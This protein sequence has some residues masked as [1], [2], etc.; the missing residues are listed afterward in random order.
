MLQPRLQPRARLPAQT[1][2]DFNCGCGFHGGDGHHHIGCRRV[3]L[4][5]ADHRC[6][7][8]CGG[9][10]MSRAQKVFESIMRTKGHSEFTMNDTG[11]YLNGALQTRWLYFQLGWEMCEVTS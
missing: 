10:E 11:K 2:R 9:I 3:N 7:D 1:Q 8:A 5:V 6:N 4:L